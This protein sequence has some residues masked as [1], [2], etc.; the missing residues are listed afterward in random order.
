MSPRPD[1]VM[2]PADVACSVLLTSAFIVRRRRTMT[3]NQNA[4]LDCTLASATAAGLA[5]SSSSLGLVTVGSG[6]VLSTGTAGTGKGSRGP[7]MYEKRGSRRSDGE[8]PDETGLPEWKGLMVDVWYH[9]KYKIEFEVPVGKPESYRD[10]RFQKIKTK[11]AKQATFKAITGV[12]GAQQ[13]NASIAAESQQ[14]SASQQQGDA[15]MQAAASAFATGMAEMAKAQA[16][17]QHAGKRSQLVSMLAAQQ[18]GT[19]DGVQADLAQAAIAQDD[20]PDAGQDAAPRKPQKMRLPGQVA[21]T[22]A[23]GRASSQ[24]RAAVDDKPVRQQAGPKAAAA[25]TSAVPAATL[26]SAGKPLPAAAPKPNPAKPSGEPDPAA[27]PLPK[28]RGVVVSW[29]SDL[30]DL[31]G[32]KKGAAVS[33]GKLQLRRPSQQAFDPAE[34]KFFN[35]HR[36]LVL[37]EGIGHGDPVRLNTELKRRYQEYQAAAGGAGG[38]KDALKRVAPSKAAAK[39]SSNPKKMRMLSSKPQ[40]AAAVES[41]DDDESQADADATGAQAGWRPDAWMDKPGVKFDKDACDLFGK[42][43]E[44]DLNGTREPAVIKA[45]TPDARAP[46]GVVFDSQP[47]TTRWENL[48]RP[49]R[50]DW[51]EIGWGGDDLAD[52]ETAHLRPVCPRCGVA[53]DEGR[54]AW[55]K[56]LACGECE[57]GVNAAKVISRMNKDDPY[58]CPPPAY[59]ESD[60]E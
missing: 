10:S 29:D 55:T 7:T 48:L 24:Q 34:L 60:D 44:M 33:D 47:D 59:G 15:H 12:A 39:V 38:K 46:Y 26:A 20:D 54:A 5:H 3:A 40:S 51:Q 56:C 43:I 19:L 13:Q 28:G 31:F 37:K 50:T 57:P 6:G 1:A 4:T 23:D 14:G 17:Q 27:K 22:A 35:K 53:L 32:A 49:G 9:K 8:G 58:R 45:Y 52:S 36:P 21:A 16:C 11:I 41:S 30:A 42:R 2:L 25:P 18:A